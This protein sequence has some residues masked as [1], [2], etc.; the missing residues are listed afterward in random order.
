M[1][2]STACAAAA[3]RRPATPAIASPRR[4]STALA[5]LREAAFVLALFQLYRFARLLTADEVAVARANAA[6]VLAVQSALALPDERAVQQWAL[7][8]DG[9]AQAANAYY[10]ALHFPVVIGLLVWLF[11]R[12]RRHYCWLRDVLFA[13]TF[14]SL[15]IHLAMPLAPPRMLPGFV[16][17]GVAHGMSAYGGAVGGTANQIA[18]MPSLHVA[19]SAAVALAVVAVLR[20][21]WRWLVLVHPLLTTAVVV[22][23]ANHYWLDAGVALV[24]LAG[25]AVLVGPR[26]R[27]AVRRR[28]GAQPASAASSSASAAQAR[29]H[30]PR[31]SDSSMPCQRE[32]GSPTPVTRTVAPG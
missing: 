25:A 10:L 26:S 24:L 4:R 18:A 1:S 19:W 20:S 32:A 3:D 27:R 5:A 2:C 28:S 9:L 22:V 11:T 7:Q 12:H 6:D 23:T 14:S 21:R 15:V 29:S 8:L 17:T 13:V 30:M 16:D 31:C